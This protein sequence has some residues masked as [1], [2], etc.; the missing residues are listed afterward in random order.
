MKILFT[1]DLH[2]NIPARSRRTGRTTFDAFAESIA[3]ETPDAVV[4]AG[5]IG[6][7]DKASEHLVAIRKVVGDLPL[8][9]CLGNHDLWVSPSR[10]D[11]FGS[12]AD[13]VKRFWREPARD[14]GAVLLD[15]ENAD[16]GDVV[17]IGGYGHFDLGHA[18]PNLRVAGM[19]VTERIYL[20]GG[21]GGLFWRDFEYIPNC[22]S[23]LQADARDQA[24]AIAGRL[25]QAV[26]TGKRVLVATHTCPWRELN[27]HP[28]SG[29]VEDI[30]SAY[31][32]NSLVGAELARR[33]A[34][35]EFLICGHT[36]MPVREQSLSGIR[37]LN[38]GTDYGYF[39]GVIYDTADQSVRW[40]GEPVENVTPPR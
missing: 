40:I 10:H 28:I 34:A 38:V 2:L 7:P 5:D 20:S 23:R 27:G 24:A 31:S 18:I 39:R 9:C 17:I 6:I 36:H 13:V 16:L 15:N 32:G 37:A 25:D 8:I 33:S 26:G 19:I 21:M 35:I 4:I 3:Q 22:G 11:E 1:A 14:V 30:L 12:L 29:G